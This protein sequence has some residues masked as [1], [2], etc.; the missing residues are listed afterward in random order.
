MVVCKSPVTEGWNDANSGG[1][2]GPELKRAGFDGIFVSG[3]LISQSIFSSKMERLKLEMRGNSG[4]KT[5]R[6]RRRLWFEKRVK[7]SFGLPSSVLQVKR[8]P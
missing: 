7:A 8:S 5:A 6:R 2:F 1:F 3:L 4:E